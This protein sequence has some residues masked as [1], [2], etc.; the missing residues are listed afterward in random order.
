MTNPDDIS[1]VIMLLVGRLETG[2]PF[3]C[4]VAVKPSQYEAFQT[5]Q[6]E[7]RIDLY[8]FDEFGEVVVSAEGEQP[9]LKVTEEVGRM[10]GTDPRKFFRDIDPL[11][12][13]AEK[14]ANMDNE[15][16]EK[17]SDD[18]PSSW[19]SRFKGKKKP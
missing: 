10:Y 9:P 18:K 12:E 6:N 3:W 2:G 15:L 4:Y 1:R 17:P 19:A 7:G 5:A 16:E 11:A 8:N 14:I 13:I